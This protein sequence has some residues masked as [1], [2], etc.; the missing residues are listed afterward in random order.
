MPDGVLW[1]GSNRTSRSNILEGAVRIFAGEFG[2]AT[3]SLRD[4]GGNEGVLSPSGLPCRLVFVAGA[5]LE[6]QRKGPDFWTG[7]IADPSGV[8]EFSTERPDS[9]LRQ[10]LP[11]LIPPSFVT[12]I[13]QTRPGRGNPPAGP[14]LAVTEIR[15]TERYVRDLWILRTAELTVERLRFL[16]HALQTGTDDSL[17]SA[18]LA[19]YK[20]K[21][22]DIREM[23]D[24]VRHALATVSR[25]HG[26]AMTGEDVKE[27][28]LAIIRESAGKTGISLDMIIAT[29][30]QSGID[31]ARA[32]EAVKALVEED[33]CYQPAKDVFKPL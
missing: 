3:L 15:Q 6:V 21:E 22:S 1:S 28:V 4:A 29:A 7:R 16:A 18:A 25:S 9:F 23:A 17:V 19:Y 32:R 20:T 8:F 24:V 12:V 5:L 2:K 10:S 30:G 13:A 26:T 27:K 31:G 14:T 33:E 11:D